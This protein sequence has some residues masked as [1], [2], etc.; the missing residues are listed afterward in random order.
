M[1]RKLTSN[2]LYPTSDGRPMAETDYHRKLMNILIQ[3]LGRP[4]RGRPGH[5]RLRQTCPVFYRP[6]DKRRHVSPDCMVVS[7]GAFRRPAPPELTSPGKKEKGPRRGRR[8][9]QQ[10]HPQ[11]DIGAKFELYRDVL[12]VK[13]CFLFDPFE[14]DLTPSLQGF[15]LRAGAVPADSARRPVASR[16]QGNSA[17]TWSG[18]DRRSACGIRRPGAWLPTPD[19]VIEAERARRRPGWKPKSARGR[20][21]AGP[22]A[23]TK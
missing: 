4:L 14:D 17:C 12:R 9:D 11:E 20:P 10:D 3:I 13:E 23:D 19:E 1:I 15:R 18:T 8:T 16:A 7:F 2:H 5:V 6:N 22:L 21:C